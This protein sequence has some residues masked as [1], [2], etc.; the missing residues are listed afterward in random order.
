MTKCI[1]CD[2]VLIDENGKQLQPAHIDKSLPH[3]MAPYY[4]DRE[5]IWA[6]C[7]ACLLV[8]T[9]QIN[10]RAFYRDLQK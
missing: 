8:A 9:M 2:A 5:V 3:P 6:R 7:G 4:R 10:R 1:N